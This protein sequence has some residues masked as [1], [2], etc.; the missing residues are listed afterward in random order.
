[1]LLFAS[2]N[3][4]MQGL[5]TIRRTILFLAV[6]IFRYGIFISLYEKVNGKYN[7]LFFTETSTVKVKDSITVDD[8]VIYAEVDS[9]IIDTV[10]FNQLLPYDSKMDR[11]GQNKTIKGNIRVD[12][13]FPPTLPYDTMRFEFYIRDRALH[14]SNIEVT[15]DFTVSDF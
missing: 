5:V 8:S 3:K 15:S 13:S 14:K 2:D 6:C 11:V 12:I 9:L 10:T 1:M 7:E 4:T